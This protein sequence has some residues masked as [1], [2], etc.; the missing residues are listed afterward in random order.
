M[1]LHFTGVEPTTDERAAVDQVLGLP[2]SGWAGADRQISRD[3]RAAFGGHEAR[4]S[5]HRLLPVLHAIQ[6]RL[7]WIAP[8]ALNYA[9]LRLNVPPAEAF[10]VAD[11][12]G[13]FSV[14]PRPPAV[15]HV[16]DDIAC[17][18]HGAGD[19]C[20]EL[21]HKFGPAGSIRK[22]LTPLREDT[23]PPLDKGGLEGG[24][25]GKIEAP[26][27]KP[28]LVQRW[29][30]LSPTETAGQCTWLRSPCL[31]LCERAPAA[32]FSVAGPKPVDRA[33]API[34]FQQISTWIERATVESLPEAGPSGASPSRPTPRPSGEGGRRSGDDGA[35]E[36]STEQVAGPPSVPQA[37]QSQLKLLKRIGV[38]NPESLDAYRAHGGYAALEK[39]LDE[40]SSFVLHAVTDSRLLGRG[41]AAFP[42]GRKWQ[43]IANARKPS[44]LICN[45]DESEPG[46][47]K[48]R[49]IM[50]G[51][52]FALIEAMTIAGFATGCEKGF[53]YIRG[54][55]PLATERLTRAIELAQRA[56]LLGDDIVGRGV[57]F[58]IELSRGAGAYICGEETALFN[59]IE[60]FRGEPRNKPPFPTESGLFGQPTLVNNVE[61]LVNVPG[62]VLDGG[63]AYATVGTAQSTGNKL[64][65]VSGH[66]A[67]PG[68]YEAPFGTTLRQLIDLAGGVAG[69]GQLQ[70][71]LLG[72]AAGAFVTPEELEVPLT[73]EGTRAIGA[74][75]GSAV[76]MLFDDTVD[77][78]QILLRIGAFFREESCGQCV[79]CRVGTVRQEELLRRLAENRPL[80]SVQQELAMHREL[81]QVMRDSSICGLG[82]TASSAIESALKKW[83]VFG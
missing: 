54:E 32:M 45:A 74:T 56:G 65:C 59:S 14:T 50:E 24:A 38:A 17:L 81:G 15:V 70:A 11:F 71:V 63:A 9:C 3:G 37:G 2:D 64:F 53:I 75:L 25:S 36:S 5:R 72:G 66:V 21:E 12:Y 26:P 41:G 67:R 10:G 46:T 34:N 1:D 28:L 29:G 35:A 52:P 83:K 16:C 73:F 48:D 31:G 82:H 13:L 58:E 68:V 60:G 33:I 7:G 80:E 4:S 69:S 8:G 30:T 55:Y 23:R 49:V 22:P 61:T 51:D 78:K 27:S 43:A 42:A 19:L 20:A 79:P 40:G 62:I 47:F 44:Y 76:V 39:A 6:S 57:R 77:L 18:T